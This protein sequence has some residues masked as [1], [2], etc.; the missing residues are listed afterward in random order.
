M[1][2]RRTAGNDGI[3]LKRPVQAE[4]TLATGETFSSSKMVPL[5]G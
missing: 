4:V 2:W 3:D 5:G 1:L